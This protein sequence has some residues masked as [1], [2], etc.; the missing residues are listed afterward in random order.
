MEK[1]F[2]DL[3]EAPAPKRR[4]Q[5][6]REIL[7]NSVLCDEKAKITGSFILSFKG[8]STGFGG[9]PDLC[10]K[11]YSELIMKFKEQAL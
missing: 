8:H 10:D 9:P 7:A 6:S 3:C 11:C 5:N 1:R 2:C 4:H